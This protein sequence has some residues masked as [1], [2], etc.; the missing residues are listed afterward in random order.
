VGHGRFPYS[1]P[2]QPPYPDVPVKW[3]NRR[4]Q[5][6]GEG[7]HGFALLT[8]DRASIHVDYIDQDGTVSNEEDL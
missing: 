1:V 3:V 2:P 4:K 7:I 5:N 6:N 8:I